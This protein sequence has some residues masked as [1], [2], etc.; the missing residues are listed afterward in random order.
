EPAAV[1]PERAEPA[2]VAAAVPGPASPP[3]ESPPARGP[4]GLD[5]DALRRSWPDVLDWLS[6][7]KRVTWTFVAQNAQIAEY[8]GERVLLTISTTG[9]AETFRRGAHAEYVRQALIDVLG[10]DARVEG[11]P[12]DTPPA[13]PGQPPAAPAGQAADPAPPP[14]QPPAGEAPSWAQAPPSPG[15]APEWAAPP[16][17]AV[18]PAGP[19]EQ[20]PA[21]EHVVDDTA[22][23]DDDESIEDLTDVG[24]PVV[25]RILGGTVI[26]ED[27][28]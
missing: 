19:P 5:T 6:R 10:V 3:A 28:Q 9:L 26:R 8:D 12:D 1:A 15:T 16:P 14:A 13:A 27:Q 11:R 25:E 17:S 4:G 7:H 18:A 21:G 20:A 2:V 22:I 23:S 24:L